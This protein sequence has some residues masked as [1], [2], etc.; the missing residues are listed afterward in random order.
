MDNILVFGWN[1][2]EHNQRVEAVL[3]RI[4]DAGVTLNKDKCEFGKSRLSF[5][6][7]TIDRDGVHADPAKTSAILNMN[8]PISV[9][10]LRRFMGMINQLG[11]FT[12]NLAELTQPLR[13]LLS[14]RSQWLWGPA[15]SGAFDRIKKELSNPAS[16]AHYNPEAPTKISADASSYGLGAVLL[17]LVQSQWRPIAYASQSMTATERSY[18][19]I[20][21]E[22]LAA[23]WACEKFADYILGR[24]IVIETDHKPLVPLLGT[25]SLDSLPPRVLRFRL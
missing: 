12:P 9:P 16:L 19:Q 22:A 17:Q 15:Q 18:A 7:H 1:T 8:P 23:T 5:L 21:K 6:G 13:E 4:Q 14:K 2:A 10:E 20:E 3:K 11:K 25:K 24:S